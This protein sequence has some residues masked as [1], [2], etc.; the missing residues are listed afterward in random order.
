MESY[1]WCDVTYENESISWKDC[2]HIKKRASNN[3]L[4]TTLCL[5]NRQCNESLSYICE[6]KAFVMNAN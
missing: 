2:I 5:S 4:N 1:P 3:R 6:S